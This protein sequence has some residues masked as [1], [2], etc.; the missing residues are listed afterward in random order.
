[1]VYISSF[2]IFGKGETLAP[3]PILFQKAS[4]R[5]IAEADTAPDTPPLLLRP[6]LPQAQHRRALLQNGEGKKGRGGVCQ[7]HEMRCC[8]QRGPHQL[9]LCKKEQRAMIHIILLLAPWEGLDPGP[10]AHCISEGE[11]PRDCRN[12]HSP[13]HP[14]PPSPHL[15]VHACCRR[16]TGAHFC[17][18]G[19]GRREGV[20]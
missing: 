18:K 12:G 7:G 20:V 10:C 2:L 11:L 14:F 3:V 9:A 19:R 5:K 16:N 8:P 6:R 4:S 1:M 13:R 15:N 17:K